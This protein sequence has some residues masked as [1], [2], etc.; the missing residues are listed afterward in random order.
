VIFRILVRLFRYRLYLGA[1]R[2][3]QM[4]FLWRLIIRNHNNGAIPSGAPDHGKTDPSVTGSS[5]NNRRA[6]FKP[7]LSFRV[8][9]DS[10]SG[11]IFHRSSRI[12]EFRLSQNLTARQFGQ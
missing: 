4:H 7:P 9:D 11:S 2:T 3:E 8:S 6:W 12:H 1:E 5:L 10:V